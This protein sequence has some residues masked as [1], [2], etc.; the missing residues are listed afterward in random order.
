MSTTSDRHRKAAVALTGFC[1]FLGLYS[2]QPLLPLLKDAFQLPMTTIGL[3]L[4]VSTAAIAITAPFVGTFAGRFGRNR[5]IVFASILIALPTALAGV[6]TTFPEVLFWRILQ[7]VL[8]PAISATTVAYISDE[9]EGGTSV[10]MSYYVAGTVMGGFFGRVVC[11]LVGEWFTWRGGFFALGLLNLVGGIAIR[12][13][14]PKDRHRPAHKQSPEGFAIFLGHLTNA[15]LL[16]TCAVGFCG[17]FMLLAVFTYVNFYLAAPPFE[18]GTRALGFLFT[19]Y[20]AGAAFTV[21][22]GRMTERYGHRKAL[23]AAL[24]ACLIGILLTLIPSAAFVIFGLT[25]FCSGAF[26]A[27]ATAN[28]HIGIAA[29]HGRGTAVGMYVTSYYLGG[30]F[31]ATIPGYLWKWGGWTTCVLLVS[32]VILTAI[33]LAGIFWRGPRSAEP[34]MPDTVP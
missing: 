1:A 28:G 6:A 9:W 19:V 3:I 33:L 31:A 24:A 14:L 4:T 32:V 12:Q 26:V 2:P 17:L 25:L 7:G 18:W 30:S 29:T 22:S 5:T 34:L 15:R 10:A 23:I 13:W 21:S 8:T 27:Q 20:L 11:A 16:T